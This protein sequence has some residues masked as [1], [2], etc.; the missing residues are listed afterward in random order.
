MDHIWQKGTIFDQK[1]HF[2]AKIDDFLSQ[3]SKNS[4]TKTVEVVQFHFKVN[5]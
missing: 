1:D 5:F 3:K 4:K 2:S